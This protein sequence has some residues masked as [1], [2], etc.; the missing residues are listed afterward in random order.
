MT[1]GDACPD[2]RPF[3]EAVTADQQQA[4]E[5]TPCPLHFHPD[6]QTPVLGFDPNTLQ[7]N[8]EPFG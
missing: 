7:D 4:Y 6:V 8:F 3:L 1:G 5:A 2:Y